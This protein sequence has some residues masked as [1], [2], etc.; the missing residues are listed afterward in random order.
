MGLDRGEAVE[1]VTLDE[2]ASSDD[3][4]AKG[5]DV[6]RDSCVEA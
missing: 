1:D 6:Y 4:R 5:V 3:C 2:E